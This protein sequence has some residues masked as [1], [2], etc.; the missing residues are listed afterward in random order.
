MALN[1]QRARDHGLPD[2]NTVRVEYGLKPI[3]DFTEI[4]T[5]LNVEKPEVCASLPFVV[6][7]SMFHQTHC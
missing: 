2:Y 1:I 4:N 7:L 5:D 6:T 3:E